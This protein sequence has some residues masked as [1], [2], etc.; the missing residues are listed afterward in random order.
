[1]YLGIDVGGT[2]TLLA[3]FDEKGEILKE[4]KFPTPKDYQD[5]LAELEKALEE[6]KDYQI[7]AC[8]CAI[9]GEV[10]RKNGLG[11]RFGNF[12]WTNIP[13]LDSIKKITGLSK[14]YLENDAK[15]AGL[16]EYIAE[17][18]YK[19]LLYIA[20]GTG[21]GIAVVKEG[22]IQL[23]V[24]D[25]GGHIFMLD[26]NGQ[27]KTWD[28]VSSGRSIVS[29]YGKKASEIDDPEIWQKYVV[30]L[31]N[32]LSQLIKTYS[33]DVVV[34]GG[35]VGAHFKKYGQFLLDE[36]NKKAEGRAIPPVLQAK[37]P[38]EAVIYGCYDFIRQS[39]AKSW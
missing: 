5:F 19:N 18:N 22:E 8:C 7:V 12:A 27:Q 3:V 17:V 11:V 23:D 4:F 20:I 34:I 6:F 10:D 15:L 30:G 24:H 26:H 33:P 32:G 25:L 9:P 1:M 39:L 31:A 29:K 16:Y 35:G 21:V 36:L 13:L 37:R 14:V 28:E 2:K 38:E